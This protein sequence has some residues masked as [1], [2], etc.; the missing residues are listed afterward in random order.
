MAS[1]IWLIAIVLLMVAARRTRR[2]RRRG[3]VGSAAAGA[4]YGWLNED[5]R[6]AV[7]IV[8]EGRAE[9]RDPEDRDGNLPDLAGS[10]RE[11]R[12]EG[13]ESRMG[14]LTPDDDRDVIVHAFTLI[15]ALTGEPLGDRWS[16]WLGCNSEASFETEAEA[17]SVAR[18]LADEYGRPAWLRKSGHPMTR[19]S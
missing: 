18:A 2:Q 5:K 10:K 11:V 15:D 12:K 13:F 1:A 14:A 16:V 4:I 8:V 7:E 19:I 9:A 17:L 3:G 6:K